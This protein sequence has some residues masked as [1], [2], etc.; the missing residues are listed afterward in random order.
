MGERRRMGS[1]NLTKTETI[2]QGAMALPFNRPHG[3]KKVTSK[4]ISDFMKQL[5]KHPREKIHIKQIFE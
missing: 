4:S 3:Q 1:K 5:A 2:E